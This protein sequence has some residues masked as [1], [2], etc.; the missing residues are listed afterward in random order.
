MINR[1]VFVHQVCKTLE[2][3]VIV[4]EHY[5]DVFGPTLSEFKLEE[6]NGGRVFQK[7]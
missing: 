7:R 5:R 2:I 6:G 1:S 4:T 3:P